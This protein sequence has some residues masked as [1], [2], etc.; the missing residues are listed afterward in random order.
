MCVRLAIQQSKVKLLSATQSHSRCC[1]VVRIKGDFQSDNT[2]ERA[3]HYTYI[4]KY[5]GGGGEKATHYYRYETIL[6]VCFC[7]R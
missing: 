3:L 7:L 4:Q 2:Y 5:G 1:R 6:N